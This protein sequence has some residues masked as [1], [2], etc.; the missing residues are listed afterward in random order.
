M[1]AWEARKHDIC[2]TANKD[3]T[4]ILVGRGS[5]GK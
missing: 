4:E 5:C 2:E 1:L 3:T